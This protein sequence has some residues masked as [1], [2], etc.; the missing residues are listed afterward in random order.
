MCALLFCVYGT[1]LPGVSKIVQLS[2]CQ[3]LMTLG[4]HRLPFGIHGH[5]NAQNTRSGALRMEIAADRGGLVFHLAAQFACIR[6]DSC[7]KPSYA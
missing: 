4:W 3:E 2:L 7:Q 6:K 5:P 1:Q